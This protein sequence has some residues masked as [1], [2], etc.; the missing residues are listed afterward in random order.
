MFG[1]EDPWVWSAYVLCLASAALCILYGM[2]NWN[3][4]DETVDPED[5]QWA[6]EE[7]KVEDEL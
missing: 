7:K 4:G 3:R 6:E 5:V 1:I 2:L